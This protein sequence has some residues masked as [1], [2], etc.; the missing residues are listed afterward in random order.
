MISPRVMIASLRSTRRRCRSRSANSCCSFS[1][2]RRSHSA[3]SRSRR[4]SPMLLQKRPDKK[5]EKKR[6]S[7]TAEIDLGTH[8]NNKHLFIPHVGHHQPD[9]VQESELDRS[10]ILPLPGGRVERRYWSK[11]GQHPNIL[12]SVSGACAANLGQLSGIVRGRIT[13]A[14]QPE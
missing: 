9:A 4:R 8:R 13:G 10:M 2:R 7:Q 1:L 5:V 11:S 14:A 12:L 6:N 3:A